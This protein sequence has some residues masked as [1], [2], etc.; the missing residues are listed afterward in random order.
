MAHAVEHCRHQLVDELAG[1][2]EGID[3][4][5]RLGLLIEDDVI[6]VVAV[7]PQAKFSAHPVVA[8]RRTKYLRNRRGKRGHHFLQTDDFFCQLRFVLLGREV[9]GG[10][11]AS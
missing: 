11:D 2:R 8:D 5:T 10:H 1:G 3:A 9:F 4:N 6:E 7:V